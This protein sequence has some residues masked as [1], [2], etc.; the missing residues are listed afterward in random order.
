MQ[1]MNRE[2]FGRALREAWLSVLCIAAISAVT[3]A[4][5]FYGSKMSYQKEVERL[6][7]QK[8]RAAMAA[9]PTIS[10]WAHVNKPEFVDG[11]FLSEFREVEALSPGTEYVV[12]R[13]R[14]FDRNSGCR[15]HDHFIYDKQ[16]D[17]LYAE[18]ILTFHYRKLLHFTCTLGDGWLHPGATQE[19]RRTGAYTYLPGKT[20]TADAMEGWGSGMSSVVL[21]IP[22]LSE[23]PGAVL[24][25]ERLG[26][27]APDVPE[28]LAER[29]REIWSYDVT[30]TAYNA[31][32]R[33]KKNTDAK[34][35]TSMTVRVRSYG[36]WDLT[37]DE[38]Y[39]CRISNYNYAPHITVEIL[40]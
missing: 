11:R 27:F 25:T 8:A 37:C 16:D 10:A 34:P 36:T 29:T 12:G 38:Y 26:D 23:M 31:D 14:E 20:D 5:I 3:V 39:R 21:P 32:P 28:E 17:A 30:V 1:D 19:W 33:D 9:S 7:I 2:E 4:A 40:Q 6:E 15:S 22:E 35:V 18:P 24:E 13:L